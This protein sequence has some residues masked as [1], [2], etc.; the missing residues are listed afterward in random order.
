MS[1]QVPLAGAWVGHLQQ[2][3]AEEHEL[4]VQGVLLPTV[5]LLPPCQL[6]VQ[7]LVLS[8]G[9]TLLPVEQV[10]RDLPIHKSRATT[11]EAKG[12]LAQGEYTSGTRHIGLI[13]G[14]GLLHHG[15][16]SLE[17]VPR[18]HTT[19]VS[20]FPPGATA[21]RKQV[22]KAPA[23]YRKAPVAYH[24]APVPSQKG[25]SVIPQSGVH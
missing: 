20:A 11:N 5:H 17:A 18:R 1:Y 8:K 19:L 4:A 12:P 2:H 10:E 13:S 14:W 24:T 23:T 6:V 7:A 16:T 25:A 22:P 3:R 21:A 15:I 9:R